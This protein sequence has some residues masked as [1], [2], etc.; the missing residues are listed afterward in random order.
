M[1]SL[2]LSLMRVFHHSWGRH[3]PFSHYPIPPL[4]VAVTVATYVDHAVAVATYVDSCIMRLWPH[5]FMHHEAMA[6]MRL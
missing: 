4:H 6:S 5:M 3:L 1:H 2:S